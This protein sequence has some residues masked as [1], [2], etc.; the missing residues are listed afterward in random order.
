MAA[1]RAL[2]EGSFVS[3]KS[4]RSAARFGHVSVLTLDLSPLLASSSF[5]LLLESE[6]GA[7]CAFEEMPSMAAGK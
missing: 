7:L 6:A 4:R 1:L 2:M 5:S 3:V